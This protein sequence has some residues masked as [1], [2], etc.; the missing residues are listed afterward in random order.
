MDEIWICILLYEITSGRNVSVKNSTRMQHTHSEMKM[1]V[2]CIAEVS[3]ALRF[4]GYE[5]YG[6][7][8]WRSQMRG[9]C[10]V[11]GNQ[12]I[13]RGKPPWSIGLW[14]LHSECLRMRWEEEEAWRSKAWR[15]SGQ[16]AW[17][18]RG[19][20]IRSMCTRKEMNKD[21]SADETAGQRSREYQQQPYPKCAKRRYVKRCCKV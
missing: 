13:C 14:K 16:R 21:V 19:K 15:W 1:Q 10:T 9:R 12:I 2:R 18:W 6:L 3:G 8:R 11:Y 4:T 17:W 20:R 5:P 7:L